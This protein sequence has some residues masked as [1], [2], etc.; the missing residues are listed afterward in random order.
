MK[1]KNG[2]LFN[3]NNQFN[4]IEEKSDEEKVTFSFEENDEIPNNEDTTIIH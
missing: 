1:T 3:N 2:D 4:N